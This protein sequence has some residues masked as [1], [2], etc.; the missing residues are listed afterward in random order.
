MERIGSFHVL[1]APSL[2]SFLQSI[3]DKGGFIHL[4]TT[5]HRLHCG[6]DKQTIYAW[7]GSGIICIFEEEGINCKLTNKALKKLRPPPH[8]FSCG[9]SM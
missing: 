1:T 3:K 8:F 7:D 2:P 9:P 4:K 6:G 5:Q